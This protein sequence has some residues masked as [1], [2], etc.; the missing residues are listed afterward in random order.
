MFLST[1]DACIRPG[2]QLICDTPVDRSHSALWKPEPLFVMYSV[3]IRGLIDSREDDYNDERYQKQIAV[4]FTVEVLC[5]AQ[6]SFH[7]EREVV[8]ALIG[9]RVVT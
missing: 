5:A 6:V 3:L 4:I 2:L 9:P 8:C 1:I 7:I